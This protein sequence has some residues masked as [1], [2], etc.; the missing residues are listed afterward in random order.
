MATQTTIS[1]LRLLAADEIFN[2]TQNMRGNL[3]SYQGSHSPMSGSLAT[4]GAGCSRL[5]HIGEC[6]CIVSKP[7]DADASADNIDLKW[8]DSLGSE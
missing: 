6:S 1:C 4:R 8:R 2:K 7:L 3:S 5:D